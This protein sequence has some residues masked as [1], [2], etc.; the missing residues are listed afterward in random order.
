MPEEN[1]KIN[2]DQ[3]L[4]QVARG[5]AHEIRTPLSTVK[6]NIDLLKEEWKNPKDERER[7]THNRL[8]LLADEVRRIQDIVNLFLNFARAGDL[9]IEEFD[10]NELVAEVLYFVD[11]DFREKK[12]A[13]SRL[14]DPAA[15]IIRAD[16]DKLK[17]VLL[18]LITNSLQAMDDG[19]GE[20]FVR[21]G[22]K[23]S[24]RRV[25]IEITDTGPGMSA[26]LLGKAFQAYFSTKKGGSGLGLSIVRRIVHQLGGD[27]KIESEEGKGTQVII[28]LRREGPAE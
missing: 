16:R 10:V 23:D 1:P 21:T 27:I 15:G 22:V 5:L 18:N 13:I 24:E 14:F 20:L 2:P 7:R 19:V 26:D 4:S 3:E 9:K 28:S 17:Q 8:S 6:M 25:I 12:L 11:P